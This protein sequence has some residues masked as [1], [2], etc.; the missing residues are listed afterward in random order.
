MEDKG[1]TAL[2][3]TSGDVNLERTGVAGVAPPVPGVDVEHAHPGPRKYVEVAMILA[4]ITA[5]EVGLY[6]TTLSGLLLVS[7]LLGLAFVKFAMVA[8]Y[9]M[10]LKFDGRLLRRLFVTGIVVALGVYS[11]ALFTMDV[12]FH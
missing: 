5:V 4:V 12:L 10:H 6:Y 3:A 9:F 11:I 8:A 1:Q 7:L 2:P